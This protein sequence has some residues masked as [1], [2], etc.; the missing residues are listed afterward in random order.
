MNTATHSI[1]STNPPKGYTV[2]AW[3]AEQARQR[4]AIQ[5]QISDL[6][7]AT[8]VQALS[9]L[10]EEAQE[11]LAD[12]IRALVTKSQ[13]TPYLRPL[14]D[15]ILSAIKEEMAEQAD[16]AAWLEREEERDRYYRGL[17]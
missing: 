3:A 11:R 4:A 13:K 9:H 1:I 2:T 12:E 17:Y 5:P 10:E 7:A 16:E 14:A 8:I 6:P 15:S